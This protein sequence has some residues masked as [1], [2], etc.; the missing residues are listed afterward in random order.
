MALYAA[1]KAFVRNFSEAL[2][3][4]YRCTP[5]LVTCVSPGG[6]DTAFRAASGGGNDA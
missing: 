4:E 1:P 2:H 3:G 5:L 6:T